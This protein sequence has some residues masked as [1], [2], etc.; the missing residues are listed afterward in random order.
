M[1]AS[2]SCRSIPGAFSHSLA[3]SLEKSNCSMREA[4][5]AE[6]SIPTR[7]R[8]GSASSPGMKQATIPMTAVQTPRSITA[9]ERLR[10]P[11]GVLP[12]VII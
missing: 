5:P 12:I 2:V 3:L 1:Q 10:S 9:H 4:P 8:T 11:N 6:S 7:I